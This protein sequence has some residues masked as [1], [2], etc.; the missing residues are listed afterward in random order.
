MKLLQGIPVKTAAGMY[1]RRNSSRKM[2]VMA[3]SQWVSV[4]IVC[5]IL[6]GNSTIL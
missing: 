5:K 6:S 1:K 3:S 4:K 2:N